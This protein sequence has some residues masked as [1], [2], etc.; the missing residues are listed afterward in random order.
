MR[1][2]ITRSGYDVKSNYW[3]EGTELTEFPVG[4]NPQHVKTIEDEADS[5]GE[6]VDYASMT[7]EQLRTVAKEMGI[8]KWH[9]MGHA[10]LLE[11]IQSTPKKE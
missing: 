8:P 4:Y 1:Y 5:P 2:L 3:E 11:A 7:R 10:A 6:S 9:L